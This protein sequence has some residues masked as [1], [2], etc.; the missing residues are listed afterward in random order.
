MKIAAIAGDAAALARIGEALKGSVEADA[1][2]LLEAGRAEL[3]SPENS[4]GRFDLLIVDGAGALR[5]DLPALEAL[6][7][8]NPKLLVLLLAGQ[9]SAELLMQAMRAGVREVL[10]WPAPAGELCNAV[11]RARVRLAAPSAREPGK[12]LAFVPCKGG[13]G[14]TF[15]AT[16]L[17]FALATEQ[18]KKVLLIDLDLQH[19]DASFFLSGAPARTSITEVARQSERLDASMLS[20]SCIEITPQFFLLAAPED[21]EQ[22]V[23]MQPEQIERVLTLA[24]Q[25]YDFVILDIDHSIDALTIK[26][27]DKAD[28]IF[29]ISQL[30]V[31]Y[32]RNTKK[33]VRLFTSL[34]YPASKIRLIGNRAHAKTDLPTGQVE[35]VIGTPLFRV[36]PNDFD[37]ASASSS[38]GLS[39]LKH[40]PGS[41]ISKALKELAAE[42]AGASPEPGSWLSKIFRRS[43]PSPRVN[44]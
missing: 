23:S 38:L 16:N 28:L 6:T 25:L 11:V 15:L 13:S 30:M 42:L 43:T 32:V 2:T 1:I 39:I 5:A 10:P 17:G 8:R 20:S 7:R 31:A 36:I 34:G 9:S 24:V 44:E 27:F 40:A 29:P 12:I 4:L 19:G 21:L 14:S 33:L 26:A 3:A 37:S 41:L 22:A 18:H 35:S